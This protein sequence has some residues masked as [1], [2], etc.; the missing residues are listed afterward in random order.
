[1]SRVEEINR[2][3]HEN[4]EANEIDF[5][6]RGFYCGGISEYYRRTKRIDGN[7]LDY[8]TS[9]I[10]CL[11]FP[12]AFKIHFYYKN[13]CYEGAFYADARFSRGCEL[14]NSFSQHIGSLI[15]NEID[16]QIVLRDNIN[17]I[18]Y[19]LSIITP[20]NRPVILDVIDKLIITL[21]RNDTSATLDLVRK[22]A[23]GDY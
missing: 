3:I 1:M 10:D 23:K 20:D 4:N 15:I 21:H 14:E 6:G 13:L 18:E 5:P 16:G 22:H 2:V 17:N 9:S 8:F 12:S 7:K 19:L 11:T